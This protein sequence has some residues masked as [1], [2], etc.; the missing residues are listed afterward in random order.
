MKNGSLVYKK[1]TSFIT[2][3][4]ADDLILV[5]LANTTDKLESIFTLNPT[6]AYL[7]DQLNGTA[8]LSAISKRLSDAFGIDLARA[9]KDTA[10]FIEKASKIRAIAKASR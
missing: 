7:W 10:V 1:S 6:A 5:P 8:S 3:K 2:R 4:I 9:E